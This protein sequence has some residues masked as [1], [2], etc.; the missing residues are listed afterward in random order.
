MRQS[1]IKIDG[2]GKAFRRNNLFDG[3][4]APGPDL[5]CNSERIPCSLLQGASITD[6]VAYDKPKCQ[7]EQ[8][9]PKPEVCKPNMGAREWPLPRSS[10]CQVFNY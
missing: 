3:S 4:R 9:R 7:G 1:G 5:N 2:P 10:L 8:R 6:L